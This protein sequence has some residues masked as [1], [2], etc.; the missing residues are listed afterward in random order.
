MEWAT[1]WSHLKVIL[2]NT[3]KGLSSSLVFD[4]VDMWLVY[5]LFRFCIWHPAM[6]FQWQICIYMYVTHLRLKALTI[7]LFM[8]ITINTIPSFVGMDQ[9]HTTSKFT[10]ALHQPMPSVL[11]W[12]IIFYTYETSILSLCT[13]T[14]FIKSPFTPPLHTKCFY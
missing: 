5:I 14:L 10:H 11:N 6:F 12:K 3:V 8:Y 9:V 13:L 2:D 1:I 4:M 7:L